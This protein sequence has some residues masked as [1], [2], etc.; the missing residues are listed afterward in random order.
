MGKHIQ[1]SLD[2]GDFWDQEK[3]RQNRNRQN[4]GYIYVING[5]K[6]ITKVRFLSTVHLNEYIFSDLFFYKFNHSYV[7]FQIR[8]ANL[9]FFYLEYHFEL[10]F[11]FYL[12]S[13]CRLKYQNYDR[14]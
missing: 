14:L 4:Q 2:F 12:N 13:F 11:F 10:Q 7:V 1:E 3:H 8:T 6:Q 9:L 5:T